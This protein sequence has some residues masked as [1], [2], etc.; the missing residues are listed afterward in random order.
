MSQLARTIPDNMWLA[1]RAT[2]DQAAN[3][4][5][6]LAA[7]ARAVAMTP[8]G[9]TRSATNR[10]TI[11]LAEGTY[12]VP[13]RID[14]ANN[15]IDI[16]GLGAAPYDVKI[17]SDDA[18]GTILH[19]SHSNYSN[20]TIEN[21]GTGK[22][23]ERYGQSTAWVANNC[24]LTDTVN[25]T[26][27]WPTVPRPHRIDRGPQMV[28]SD[29]FESGW[30]LN[31][32]WRGSIATITAAT[33]WG[34]SAY[35]EATAWRED[36]GPTDVIYI[37]KSVATRDITQK[38]FVI[39]YT[40]VSNSGA[41]YSTTSHGIHVIFTDSAGKSATH[42]GLPVSVGR[43]VCAVSWTTASLSA[44]FNPADVVT[45]TLKMR[46]GMEDEPTGQ[47]PVVRF[48]DWG[49]IDTSTDKPAVCMG[50]D[51]GFVGSNVNGLWPAIRLGIPTYMAM[52]YDYIGHADYMTE[53]DL[54]AVH[55]TGLVEIC[56]HT[57][58]FPATLSRREKT[59]Y[60]HHG[61]QE[62]LARRFGT[63]AG[64]YVVPQGL[65]GG[66]ALNRSSVDDLHLMRENCNIVRGVGAYWT[67]LS[68][69]DDNQ[70]GAPNGM[71]PRRPVLPGFLP[72]S[73]ISNDNLTAFTAATTG[74]I[75]RTIAA[76][77]SLVIYA[78]NVSDDPTDPLPD[79]TV[80]NAAALFAKLAAERDAGNLDLLHLADFAR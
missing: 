26:Q 12:Y 73:K 6:L 15:G 59:D 4:D 66:T 47:P 51:D 39:G 46:G 56:N 24:I 11:A 67:G 49:E 42:V 40:V 63:D 29:M 65:T 75:D 38:A 7:I 20:L 23:V 71:T 70:D 17:T 52:R 68:G 79:L 36:S 60:L 35:L 69:T 43:H 18:D 76:G 80:A 32:A 25:G 8:R 9:A 37:H 48:E 55:A 54:S 27:Y 53:A 3:G 14:R 45:I 74:F 10:V 28:L 41:I 31:D 5:R 16:V 72:C 30:T 13:S 21:T 33:P 34:G 2:T 58:Y 57:S 22:A 64:V 61:T 19:R 77:Q 50:F 1:V 62:T 44:G 78:H